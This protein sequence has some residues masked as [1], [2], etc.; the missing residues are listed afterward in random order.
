MELVFF[1]PHN[2]LPQGMFALGDPQ[3]YNVWL[4]TNF[5]QFIQMQKAFIT[6]CHQNNIT[7][8]F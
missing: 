5:R 2:I 7:L 4:N 3:G 6:A 1:A 8:C